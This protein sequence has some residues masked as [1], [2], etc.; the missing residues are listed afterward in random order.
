[1]GK[2]GNRSKAAVLNSSQYTQVLRTQLGTQVG[3]PRN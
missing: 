1:M 2:R 3:T